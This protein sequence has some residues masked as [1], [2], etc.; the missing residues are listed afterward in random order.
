MS[1]HLLERGWH[2]RAR[3][4][5]VLRE[6]FAD[7]Q[8]GR[9]IVEALG[10]ALPHLRCN[11][12]RTALWRAAGARIG[13]RARVMGPLHISCFGSWQDYL[14]IGADTLITG[15]LRIDLA[16]VV[17]I[18]DR[19]RIGHDVLL[20]TNDHEIGPSELRCGV[21]LPSPIHIGD[22]AWLSSRCIVLPGVSVGAGAIVAA[23]A[24]VTRDVPPDTMVA[25]IPARVVRSLDGQTPVSER[26]RLAHRAEIDAVA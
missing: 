15:P 5:R 20:L 18:G 21:L 3:V 16:A 6:D 23:G 9:T 11:M 22:G 14:S 13:D 12:L 24:V 17:R 10:A 4:S 7:L 8:P 25:G 1:L 19:V 2:L 26:V